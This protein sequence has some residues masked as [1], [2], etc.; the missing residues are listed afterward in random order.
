VFSVSVHVQNAGKMNFI[1]GRLPEIAS[2][3][4]KMEC[5][6]AA[7]RMSRD[8]KLAIRK[9]KFQHIPLTQKYAEWK[10]KEGLDKRILIATGDYVKSIHVQRSST[11]RDLGKLVAASKRGKKIS[12]EEGKD[13]DK[14]VAYTV[15]VPDGIHKPSGL[16]YSVLAK[17]HE[18]GSKKRNIPARPHW[19]P[20]WKDFE[21]KEGKRMGRK[22][23][24]KILQEFRREIAKWAS[25]GKGGY[26]SYTQ[27]VGMATRALQRWRRRQ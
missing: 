19:G 8:L 23:S 22:V 7:R 10:E 26:H 3:I 27:R 20:V 16:P 15:T 5:Y 17:I 11:G 1:L 18:F 13:K 2:K 12:K 24:L 14:C 25:Y 6:N 9:Q 21:N 4:S